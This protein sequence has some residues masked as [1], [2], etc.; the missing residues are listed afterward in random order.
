MPF[1]EIGSEPFD[2]IIVG[3]GFA[4]AFFL[5]RYL[6]TAPATARIAVLERGA[7]K[8]HA[9]RIEQREILD[10]DYARHYRRSGDLTKNWVFNLGFGGGSNCWWGNVPRFLPADFEMQT[11]FGVGTDWPI[12]YTDLSPYYDRAEAMMGISGPVEPG[13]FPGRAAY[14][15]P[16]HRMTDPERLLKAAYPDKFF[17][18]PSAR[19]RVATT[20]RGPCCGNGVCNMCPVDAKFTILNGM[21]H[22]FEDPRATV[23]VDA[24]VRSVDHDA[25]IAKGVTYRHRGIEKRAFADIVVLAANAVFNP[26]VLKQSGIDH[27]MLGRRL[28]EQ[29]GLIAEALLDGVDNFQG[30]TSV[31]GIGYMLYDDDAR[32]REMAGCLLE[33][34]NVGDLRTEFGRWRQVLPVRMVFDSLPDAENHVTIDPQDPDRPVMHYTGH[35]DYTSKAIARARSD[36]ERVLAPLPVEAINIRPSVETSEAHIIGT[37]LMGNDPETSIVDRDC[38]HHQVRNLIVLGSS[39]FPVGGLANPSLTIA[40]QAMRTADRMRA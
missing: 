11:R 15:L 10:R 27:P 19:A 4:G 39:T 13:L 21:M 24:E 18:M 29:V 33:T 16:P 34:W 9:T 17:S 20:G 38:I 12:T 40:A 7:L 32:R 23:M 28:H 6:E 26:V 37:T 8:D 14:P 3:T 5:A 2:V 36:L 30:S 22:V 25:G 31:T 35:G 1:G